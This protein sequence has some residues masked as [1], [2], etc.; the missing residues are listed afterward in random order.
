MRKA[1]AAAFALALA[2]MAPAAAQA[3]YFTGQPADGPS[4]DIASLGGIA[5][6][7]DGDGHVIYLKRDAGANH[8]FVSFLASGT[9]RAPLRIDTGQLTASAEPR[10]GVSDHGRAVA[11]WVN[12][13]SVWASLRPTDTDDWQP[14][15][16]VYAAPPAGTG[17]RDLQLSMGP[18]GAAYATFELNG[19]V[20]V[21][22]LAATTWTLLDAP[23]DID[24]AAAASD[25]TIATSADGTAL[26]VWSESGSVWARRIARTRLSTAPQ[27]ASIDSLDGAGGGVAD[28]PTAD[29]EDDSSFAW[30]AFRQDF[31][32][33]SRVISRRLVGSQF[34][35]TVAIDATSGGAEAPHID[36]TGRGRGLAALSVRGSQLT[37]ADTLGS[38]N[39][40]D[41]A[42][43]LGTGAPFDPHAVSAISENGRGTV[44][45][46]SGAGGGSQLFARFWNARRFEDTSSLSDPT[47]GPVD[48]AAGIDAAADAGG[49]QAV[50]YVQGDGADRRVM[51]AVFDKEPRATGGGNHDDW[52]RTRGFALKWSKV[53]DTWGGIEYHVDVD[54]L[55]LTTT[56]RTSASVSGLPDGR[57]VYS[58]TAVDSR[59]QGTEGPNR[60]L[61]VDLT[62]PTVQLTA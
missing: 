47:L 26:A 61:Y 35:D 36:M 31:G 13:G 2:G 55:P 21:A 20:R 15:Q 58:V 51:V 56:T 34:Q 16:A 22:R 33:V 3:A 59:G 27:R 17:A 52:R 48:G 28:S 44:A 4:A 49:N 39:K 32:G 43:G 53:E 62:A 5:L 24:P 54:G 10:V 57:H 40:W 46:Q 23:V 11:V 19:D 41:P 30:V 7:R 60:L 18:S 50:A 45:W 29:V 8:V 37:I 12:G 6:S 1:L 9:P 25:A 14:P 38:D 42:T